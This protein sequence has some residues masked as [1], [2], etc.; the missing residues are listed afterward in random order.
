MAH[1]LNPQ[2]TR[3]N[4]GEPPVMRETQN[5]GLALHGSIANRERI[6]YHQSIGFCSG[7]YDHQT[8]ALSVQGLD[9]SLM[10]YSSKPIYSMASDSPAAPD[11]SRLT[12]W[13]RDGDTI[14]GNDLTGCEEG[15]VTNKQPLGQRDARCL[16][17][18]RDTTLLLLV[19]ED[20]GLPSLLSESTITF[21]NSWGDVQ[22]VV[23]LW[24]G[25]LG[26]PVLSGS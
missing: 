12:L 5:G 16:A 25:V 14:A 10:A 23:S 19:I 13:A 21:G 24:P 9:R 17:D 20:L 11:L 6:R 8:F 1:L 2:A 4:F 7:V 3:L 15:D 22:S 26:D 18:D